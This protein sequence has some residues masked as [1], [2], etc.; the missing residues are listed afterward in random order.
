[1]AARKKRRSAKQKAW[2]KKLGAMS[3][4]RAKHKGH[5]KPKARKARRSPKQKAWA[6]KLGAMQK[7][8]AAGRKRHKRAHKKASWGTSS[9]AG[10]TVHDTISHSKSGRKKKRGKRVGHKTRKGHIPLPILVK[11]LKK[12]TAVVEKRARSGG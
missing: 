12:L 1:M 3:K 2:A 9:Y 10:V 4:A 8:K 6:K 7:A 5:K 11:R